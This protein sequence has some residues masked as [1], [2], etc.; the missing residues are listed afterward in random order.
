MKNIE[1]S[2]I[3]NA[4]NH[5]KYIRDTLE[6]FV[7]QKT[8]FKFEVLVHDDAS[9]D[10]TADIIREY[11]EKYPDIIKPIYQTENQYSKNIPIGSTYQKPR[12]KGK[13]V[14]ICEGDDYWTDPYKLQKQFDAMEKHPELDVCS[15]AAVIVDTKINNVIKYI[16]PSKKN[17]VIPAEK[18]IN[19]G[20]GFVATNSLFYRAEI[21][22]NIPE[23]RKYLPLDYS[24][25]VHSSLRGGMLYLDE[26]MSAYRYM[27]TGSWSSQMETNSDKSIEHEKRVVRMLEILN[28]ET[29]YKYNKILNKKIL[30]NKS[31]TIYKKVLIKRDLERSDY[32]VIKRTTLK[33]KARILLQLKF[34]ELMNN[35]KQAKRNIWK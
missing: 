18:V 17:T 32:D 3:C 30:R 14:A 12:V 23:F 1:V 27:T 22:E 29:K 11:E 31:E 25:Q 34:P 28:E 26:C 2:I 7:M 5:E 9:T 33:W 15:H 6:S 35:L 16:K 24:L 21:D 10:K 13:Y 8:N 4:Y 20:G 19:G